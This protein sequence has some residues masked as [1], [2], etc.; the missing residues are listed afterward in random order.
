MYPKYSSGDVVACRIIR[1]S[2]FI[3]W[4]KTY[5][6]ATK[7]QGMLCKRLKPSDKESHILAVSD[8]Q[9]YPPFDIPQAEITGIA[10]IV[11]VIRLE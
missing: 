5:V 6:V 4:N 10:L 1:E 3:Q 11:G 2:N 9:E 8:N 7:E